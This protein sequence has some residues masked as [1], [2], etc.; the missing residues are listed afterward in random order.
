MPIHHPLIIEKKRNGTIEV[1]GKG[2]N[3]VVDIRPK[4]PE[5]KLEAV[6]TAVLLAGYVWTK[7]VEKRA[8][9][10]IKKSYSET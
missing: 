5:E 7:D 8:K 2:F 3:T 1:S 4:T 9:K 6:R 10:A